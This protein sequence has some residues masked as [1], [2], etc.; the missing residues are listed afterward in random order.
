MWKQCEP[1]SN[2]TVKR[3]LTVA[4]GTF[5]V[6]D[7]GDAVIRGFTTGGGS[8]NAAE[9]AMRLNITGVGRFTISLYGEAKRV[10]G[11]RRAEQDAAFAEREKTIVYYYIDGLKELSVI[12]DDSGLVDFVEDL[13]NSNMYIQVFQKSVRLAEM[14]GVPAEKILKSKSDIDSYFR[15]GK[16]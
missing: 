5:C 13:K 8:F 15:G 9:F 11:I 10:V 12:Y 14:R 6:L 4:H 7:M 2:S 1:F 3:M 16:G